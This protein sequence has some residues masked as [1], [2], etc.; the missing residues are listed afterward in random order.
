MI[1]E[2]NMRSRKR[3][4]LLGLLL[5]TSLYL[6]DKLRDRLPD[7]MGDIKDRAWET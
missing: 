7:N 1:G 5:G 3:E 2:N 6:L 4:Q